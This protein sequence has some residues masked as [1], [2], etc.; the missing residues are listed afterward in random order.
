MLKSELCSY[1]LDQLSAHTVIT[2]DLNGEVDK[3]VQ[4][5]EA[6]VVLPEVL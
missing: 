1:I 4:A 2:I 6:D 5:D 3:S